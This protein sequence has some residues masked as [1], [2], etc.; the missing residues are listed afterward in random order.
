MAS[1]VEVEA[2]G[3][4]VSDVRR[5]DWKPADELKGAMNV[6]PGSP[7]HG[8]SAAQFI[9][10]LPG[11]VVNMTAVQQMIQVG[12]TAGGLG[13]VRSPWQSGWMAYLTKPGIV[14]ATAFWADEPESLKRWK[15]FEGDWDDVESVI[16]AASFAG[17]YDRGRRQ[18]IDTFGPVLSWSLAVDRDGKAMEYRG[19]P[20]ND[21]V[22]QD[23]ISAAVIEV[24]YAFNFLNCRNIEIADARVPRTVRR[25][26][27]REGVA[28]VSEIMVLPSGKYRRS[29]TDARPLGGG[30]PLTPVRGHIVK[31]GIDGRKHLFGRDGSDGRPAVE[32]AFWVPQ[33][34]RG[35]REVGEVEQSFTLV[36]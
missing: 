9:G 6:E 15:D 27:E 17:G 31:S 30:L 4:V 25:R 26:F 23:T 36:P 2:I 7:G 11:P 28:P 16:T 18:Q 22:D 5:G 8:R 35:S 33:H 34:T 29:D 10:W 14:T 12:Q 32:G 19:T 13:C 24:C 3:R 21:A 20:F 1:V